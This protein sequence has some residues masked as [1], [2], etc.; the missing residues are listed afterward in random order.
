MITTKGKET[1][2]DKIFSNGTFYIELGYWDE[3]AEDENKFIKISVDS[4]KS[5]LPEE[6]QDKIDKVSDTRQYVKRQILVYSDDVEGTG[7]TAKNLKSSYESGNYLVL[8]HTGSEAT[9]TNAYDLLF[10]EIDDGSADNI[11]NSTD[12]VVDQG[13]WGVIDAIALY[14]GTT[15]IYA[16]QLANSITT[17]HAMQLRFPANDL[18]FTINFEEDIEGDFTDD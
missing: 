7:T 12:D 4:I 14:Q 6:H 8:K 5:H 16:N 13:G 17:A 3:D 2:W 15:L 18:S 9:V 1:L 11:N 10:P